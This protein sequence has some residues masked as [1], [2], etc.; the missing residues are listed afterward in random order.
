MSQTFNV[1][2]TGQYSLTWFENEHAGFEHTYTVS[3]TGNTTAS[4]D[5]VS[6]GLWISRSLTVSLNAGTNT[7]VF[8]ATGSSSD[9]LIDNVSLVPYQQYCTNLTVTLAAAYTNCTVSTNYLTN[10]TVVL[11]NI[12]G[13]WKADG[14]ANDS[15][16]NGNNANAISITYETGQSGQAFSFSELPYAG[17]DNAR[18]VDL[19]PVSQLYSAT[20][21]TLSA[22]VKIPTAANPSS[23][24]NWTYLFTHPAR[25]LNPNVTN[26]V[27]YGLF[28]SPS[29]STPSRR[30]VYTIGFQDGT[31]ANVGSSTPFPD[32]QWI[33]LAVTWSSASGLLQIY[34]NGVLDGTTSA[35]LGKTLPTAA[36][37]SPTGT[38]L[39][40]E[41]G[42]WDF[43]A[44]TD[45]SL[46]RYGG[47]AAAIDD[48]RLYTRALAT[49][50][51]QLVY[52]G[53]PPI[54]STNIM[55]NCVPV[56]AVTTN[57]DFCTVPAGKLRILN[58]S[59]GNVQLFWPSQTNAWYLLQGSDEVSPLSWTTVGDVQAGTGSNILVPDSTTSRP[60]RFYRLLSTEQ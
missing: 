60:R 48:F 52:N 20:E 26:D 7:L 36:Q 33:H 18:R 39:S 34:R 6:T 4:Y 51:I 9:T 3:V 8:Q 27:G 45:G 37:R 58:V 59:P 47:S 43:V 16:G 49:N 1:P 28:I 21:F 56:D 55:T 38:A 11:N 10:S 12:I 30:P 53:E 19:G 44:D 32:N 29:V 25:L 40:A 41:L 13:L 14:N 46:A 24:N 23:T 35:G 42:V 5:S 57:L 50:E 31:E 17:N 22:W 2:M 15:S 54:I